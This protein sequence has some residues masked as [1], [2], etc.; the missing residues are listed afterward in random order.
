MPWKKLRF[1]V[2]EGETEGISYSGQRRRRKTI[3]LRVGSF[4]F[5]KK[6]L[7]LGL[8]LAIF[9]VLDGFLTYVGLTLLG[10]EMEGNVFLRK[11][12]EVYGT[13]WALFFSKLFALALV[14]IL[15]GYSHKRKWIRPIIAGLCIIY[16]VL[17]VIPWTYILASS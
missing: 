5:S 14:I 15:T 16:L 12:M 7:E 6:A 4:S 13:H 8:L 17:A 3:L 1:E 2:V 10:V 11:L 9:Q